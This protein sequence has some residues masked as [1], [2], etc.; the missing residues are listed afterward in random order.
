MNRKKRNKTMP[1]CRCDLILKRPQRFH[2]KTLISDKSKG[3]GCKI[4]MEI[5]IHFLYNKNKL[6]KK[7]GKTPIHN[8]H[9]K[10]ISDKFN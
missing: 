1:T 2:L 10:N 3:A 5:S 7:S 8:S 4:N 9:Q 6:R